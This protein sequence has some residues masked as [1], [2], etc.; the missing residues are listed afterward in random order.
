[1][2]SMLTELSPEVAGDI[3]DRG[4]ILTGGGAEL[5]GL[6]QFLQRELELSVRVADE[7][8][9]A[10]VRG[11]SQL[12]EEPLL[13]RRVARTESHLLLDAEASAFET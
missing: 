3:F 6:S 11:L 8:R 4:L 5:D 2:Q 12:F 10:S 13:L 7:P 1:V 9:F